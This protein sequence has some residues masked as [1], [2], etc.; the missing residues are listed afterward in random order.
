MISQRDKRFMFETGNKKKKV[1]FTLEH[2]ALW[3]D[4]HPVAVPLL[5]R[6]LIIKITKENCQLCNYGIHNLLLH[7]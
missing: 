2:I 6:Y 3:M 5:T 7:G 1:I 4:W